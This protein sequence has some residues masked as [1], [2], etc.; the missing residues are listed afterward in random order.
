MA[1]CGIHL[2][3]KDPSWSY[4]VATGAH[5]PRARTTRITQPSQV[6]TQDFMLCPAI[7][8]NAGML[9]LPSGYVKI[10]IENGPFVS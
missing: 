8:R 1:G 7:H 2:L 6:A 9:K 3:F 10:V 5:V 4:I